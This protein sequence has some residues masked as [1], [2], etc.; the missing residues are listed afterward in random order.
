MEAASF[1]LPF[2]E[3]KDT[4]NSVLKRQI[5]FLKRKKIKK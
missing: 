4:A 1:F 5:E 2:R 3:K